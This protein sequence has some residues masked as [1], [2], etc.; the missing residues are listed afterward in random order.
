MSVDLL[1]TAREAYENSQFD[2]LVSKYGEHAAEKII[3]PQLLKRDLTLDE[4]QVYRKVKKVIQND[5]LNVVNA[6]K[7]AEDLASKVIDEVLIA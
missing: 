7:E 6:K 4:F 3:E 1:G 5:G 2:K